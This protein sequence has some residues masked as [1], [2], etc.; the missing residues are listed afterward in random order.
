MD[1]RTYTQALHEG[2]ITQT[3]VGVAQGVFLGR[4]AGLTT[5]LITV[6]KV[7]TYPGANLTKRARVVLLDTDDLE[8]VSSV[9][10]DE[11]LSI[12]LKGSHSGRGASQST[13]GREDAA[14]RLRYNVELVDFSL[15]TTITTRPGSDRVWYKAKLCR[16]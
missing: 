12:N 3:S 14:I 8:T 7:N 5:G 13:K 11:I 2:S 15:L 4:E 9:A 10:V 1:L 16:N 6:Q